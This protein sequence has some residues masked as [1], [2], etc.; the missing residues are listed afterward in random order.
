MASAN[1]SRWYPESGPAFH[2]IGG[3]EHAVVMLA[4]EDGNI[5]TAGASGGA[6]GLTDEELRA[7]AIPVSGA[8]SV[9]NF[10][11]TQ[12][13]AIPAVTIRAS[14]APAA[15][16]ASA[17]IAD[18]GQLAAGS[19][20]VEYSAAAMDTVAVGKGMLLEHRNAANNATTHTLAAISAADSMC[21]EILRVTVAA[22]ERIR[23]IAGT[24]AGAASSKYMGCITLYAIT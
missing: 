10:P 1:C 24:A 18:S 16:L 17:V 8:V 21:G 14:G 19:Y 7:A 9:S 3:A 6:G 23:W 20:R 5:Y 11:A 4:D 13:L 15:P 22:N 2:T 12:T